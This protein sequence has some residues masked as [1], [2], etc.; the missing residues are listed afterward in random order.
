M[1]C[2]A[3]PESC[4][5]SAKVVLSVWVPPWRITVAPSLSVLSCRC[6]RMA[7][8]AASRVARG[9]ASEPTSLSSP[10]V[11]TCRTSPVSS[12]SLAVS[13]LPES[14]APVSGAAAPESAVLWSLVSAAG[15]AVTP[16]CG[17]A[18]ARSATGMSTVHVILQHGGRC[19]AGHGR[20]V[21]ISEEYRSMKT[22]ARVSALADREQ[23]EASIPPAVAT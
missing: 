20:V 12:S 21:F 9:W 16:G 18:H 23:P 13:L 8:R 2:A 10:Q 6:M 5:S 4:S 7:S 17:S 22:S 3:V 15:L 11:A 14:S 19:V 1:G